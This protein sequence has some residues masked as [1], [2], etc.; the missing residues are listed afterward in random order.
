MNKKA[1]KLN[2]D[3]LKMRQKEK[4]SSYNR[5]P[6]VVVVDDVRSLFNIG[7]IF[8]ISEAGYISKIYL[9]GVCG[10]PKYE[11]DK[12]PEYVAN[13]AEREIGKSALGVVEQ[14]CWEYRKNAIEVIDSLK[15][16]GYKI[17]VLEQTDKSVSYKNV[18]YSFPLCLVVGHERKGV[19]GSVL[20]R[21]DKI[22]EIPIFGKVN[23]LN[24][25]VAYGV[26]LYEVLSQITNSDKF[27]I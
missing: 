6:I 21:A 7:S 19:K 17:F 1:V 26:V 24:V 18:S 5:F 22:V 23:S 9:C 27:G 2:T 20:K 12:R 15:K 8:R 13:R 25:A 4:A 3:K 11:G 14:V 10:H 16:E